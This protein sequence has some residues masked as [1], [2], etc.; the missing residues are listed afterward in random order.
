MKALKAHCFLAEAGQATQTPGTAAVA[1]RT[2]A[3]P[4]IPSP[5]VFIAMSVRPSYLVKCTSSLVRVG[6]P[7]HR[8]T[9]TGPRHQDVKKSVHIAYG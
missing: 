5:F 9:L 7:I 8:V 1:V 6:L 2:Q 3:I 4:S